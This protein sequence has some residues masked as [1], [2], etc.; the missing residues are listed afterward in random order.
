MTINVEATSVSTTFQVLTSIICL[1]YFV[2]SGEI[3]HLDWPYQK[4]LT[5]GGGLYLITLSHFMPYSNNRA[6]I[7]TLKHNSSQVHFISLQSFLYSTPFIWLFTHT[8]AHIC[9]MQSQSNHSFSSPSIICEQPLQDDRNLIK[10][11]FMFFV[12]HVWHTQCVW[13]C[14]S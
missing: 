2:P 7:W 11:T 9:S 12:Y 3:H 5:E 13:L 10:N 1:H 14:C 8:D 4:H 6:E